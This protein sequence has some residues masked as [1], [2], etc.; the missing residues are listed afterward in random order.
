LFLVFYISISFSNSKIDQKANLKSWLLRNKD[1]TQE[2]DDVML[3][4]GAQIVQNIRE[5]IFN[6]L[7]F[8]CSAGVA[9]NKVS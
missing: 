2:T 8:H 4:V 6:T 3:I 1:L 9:H 7:G 5:D